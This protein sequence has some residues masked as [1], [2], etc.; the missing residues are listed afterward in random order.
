LHLTQILKECFL[1]YYFPI[2][3]LLQNLHGL[4]IQKIFL[5]SRR[6]VMQAKYEWQHR[7]FVKASLLSRLYTQNSHLSETEDAHQKDWDKCHL[8]RQNL[9]DLMEIIDP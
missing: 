6:Q 3:Y 1:A 2:Q 4:S 5:R 8:S 7:D 9:P